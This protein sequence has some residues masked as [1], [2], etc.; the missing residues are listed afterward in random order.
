MDSERLIAVYD[1]DSLSLVT[2]TEAVG[3]AAST[4]SALG[5]G[6]ESAPSPEEVAAYV[7]AYEAA[8]GR[9]FDDRERTAIGA[10]ALY[11]LAYTARCEHAIDPDALVQRRARPRLAEDGDRFLDLAALLR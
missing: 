2:E 8:R 7:A 1:W 10:E 6:I 5:E 9:T 4:W 11:T 3:K